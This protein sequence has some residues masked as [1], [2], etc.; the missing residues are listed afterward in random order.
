MRR[1]LN[2]ENPK[3]VKRAVSVDYELSSL[4]SK[5]E[6][7]PSIIPLKEYPMKAVVGICGDRASLAKSVGTT[8]DRLVFR[9]SEAMDRHE[10][11]SVEERAPFME[12]RIKKPEIINH[13]PIP[14]FYREMKSRYLSSSI[15][16]ASGKEGHQ[17]SSFH[18]MMYLGGNK[19][20][21]RIVPR[22]LYEIFNRE[23]KELEVAVV[24]GVHPAIEIATATSYTPDFD[25]L[26]F[27]SSLLNGIS[28][29]KIGKL[30]VPSDAEI[31]MHG[32]ITKDMADEGPFV[33]LTGTI[34]IQRRQ[35][36]FECDEL[37]Y[38]DEPLFR[39]IVPGGLEQR[40]LMGVPQ[41]PRIY[42]IISNT[43][44]SVKNV[45]LT[46]GGCC[47]LHGVVSI[48]KRKEG[49]GKN[50]ILAALSAHPS[51]K[52]VVVVDEDIDIFDERDVEWALATR[53]QPDQD[54]VLVKN[55]RGSSLDPS[56]N[57]EEHTTAKYGIDATRPLGR[58][59]KSFARVELPFDL[60]KGDYL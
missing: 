16:I 20:S 59:E 34:D 52:G 2:A 6:A 9:L 36:I 29:T 41:E 22:H 53:F 49:D 8:K 31:V 40:M 4:A 45:Y 10:E 11:F 58:D 7:Q 17:N 35:P 5:L 13:I 26:K 51:M 57:L 60:D 28:V 14:I 39:M 54:L 27:A 47:W 38:R 56:S 24:M 48:E 42:R 50:A 33:D 44:P 19:F 55:A 18:R 12:N 15:V 37:Y 3:E 46:D 32:R 21:I 43:V 1:Y 23:E 30:L 25:E